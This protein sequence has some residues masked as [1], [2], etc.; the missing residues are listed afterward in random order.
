[1]KKEK[2]YLELANKEHH[3]FYELSLAGKEIKINYGRIG[4]AGKIK[5]ISF[6]SPEE[7]GKFFNRQIQVKLRRGY[8][9]AVKGETLPRLKGI[10]PGQLRINFEM[11]Y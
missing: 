7:S 6:K 10:H 5:L 1:M 8:A 2:I 4:R 11:K 9:K 3:K